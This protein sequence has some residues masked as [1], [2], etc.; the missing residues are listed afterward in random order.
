MHA[1]SS[2]SI[3]CVKAGEVL[4]YKW[5]WCISLLGID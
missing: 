2:R 3:F 5:R 4:L 1:E